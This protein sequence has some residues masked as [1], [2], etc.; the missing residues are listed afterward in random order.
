MELH[1]NTARSAARKAL[2][3]SQAFDGKGINWQSDEPW[4]HR[5]ELAQALDWITDVGAMTLNLADRLEAAEAALLD[6]ARKAEALK[7]DCGADPEGAQ[8]VRNAQYQ[9]IST[10]AHVALGTIRGPSWDLRMP[11][12]AI[13]ML[14]N[15]L[16]IDMEAEA[17]VSFVRGVE[18]W[19]GLAPNV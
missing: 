17:I 11:K 8:A 2:G 19:H 14:W 10:A 16:P 13:A 18:R 3:Y 7:R 5:I 15:S 4:P 1:P 9:A 6:C 12:E